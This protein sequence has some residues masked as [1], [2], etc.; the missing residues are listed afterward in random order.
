MNYVV[1]F[2]YLFR[3]YVFMEKSKVRCIVSDG[4]VADTVI[5]DVRESKNQNKEIP[6]FCNVIRTKPYPG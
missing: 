1:P 6:Y 3:L 4:K 2:I 5:V